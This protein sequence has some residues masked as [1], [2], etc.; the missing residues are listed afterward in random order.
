VS[1]SSSSDNGSGAVVTRG[2]GY[3]TLSI[4]LDDP[5]TPSTDYQ[6]A[7]SNGTETAVTAAGH[8]TQ[9]A[10]SC[11]VSPSLLLVMGEPVTCVAH[12]Q[13]VLTTHYYL[14]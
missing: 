8:Y 2:L 4:K 6:Y 10:N 5:P 13:E 14:P 11:I 9:P 3:Q 12:S 1:S 7:A